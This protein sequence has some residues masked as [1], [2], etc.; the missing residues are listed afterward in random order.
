MSFKP[1]SAIDCRSA[2]VFFPL[3]CI[4]NS[5]EM[6]RSCSHSSDAAIHAS[7]KADEPSAELSVHSNSV[8]LCQRDSSKPTQTPT[9]PA[10]RALPFCRVLLD[11]LDDAMLSILSR[12]PMCIVTPKST[13]NHMEVV[14]T[15]SRDCACISRG[16]EDRGPE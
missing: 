11:P 16:L 7:A 15:F 2:R 12:F 1:P 8:D 13:T 6:L 9:L 10:H 4:H 3:G 14:S 5:P